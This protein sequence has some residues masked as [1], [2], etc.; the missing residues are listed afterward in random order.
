[1]A[2]V[3]YLYSTKLLSHSSHKTMS[4]KTVH[5]KQKL[6]KLKIKMLFNLY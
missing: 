6:Q 5:I 3:Y 4:E 1:M 2:T